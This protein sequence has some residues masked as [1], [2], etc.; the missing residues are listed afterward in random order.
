MHRRRRR[1]PDTQLARAGERTQLL[2][3]D[4]PLAEVRFKATVM[5]GPVTGTV[6]IET[7]DGTRTADLTD[8]NRLDTHGLIS[9][10]VVPQRNTAITFVPAQG[11]PFGA[12]VVLGGALIIGAIAWTAWGLTGL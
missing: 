4:A 12:G 10:S 3:G 7:V 2:I 5:D 9:L 1:A 6:S 11:R 8:D